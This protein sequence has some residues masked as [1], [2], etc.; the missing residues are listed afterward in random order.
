[1]DESEI[2]KEAREFVKKFLPK[3]ETKCAICNSVNCKNNSHCIN[4]NC[5]L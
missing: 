4:C 2:R 1:M 3:W 5:Q